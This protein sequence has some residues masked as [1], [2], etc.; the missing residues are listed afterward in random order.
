MVTLNDG[1]TLL[2]SVDE[3]GNWDVVEW[4]VEDGK[5]NV[6]ATDGNGNTLLNLAEKQEHNGMMEY[7]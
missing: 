4:V 5:A 3:K 2:H 1:R 6:G 7:L